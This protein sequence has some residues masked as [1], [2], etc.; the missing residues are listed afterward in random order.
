[1]LTDK[2]EEIEFTLACSE[3]RFPDRRY[4]YHPQIKFYIREQGEFSLYDQTEIVHG[5]TNP[6][7]KQKFNIPCYSG[8]V[9]NL[10]FELLD[11]QSN[12]DLKFLGQAIV[13]SEEIFH[14]ANH[15][16]VI[17]IMSLTHKVCDLVLRWRVPTQASK[18]L[19]LTVEG[20]DLKSHTSSWFSKPDIKS[21]FRIDRWMSEDD[22]LNVYESAQVDEPK[23][24]KWQPFRIRSSQISKNEMRTP[25][26]IKFLYYEND[27]EKS[28]GEAVFTLDQ[29]LNGSTLFPLLDK[30]KQ[31]RLGSLRI[32]CQVLEKMNYLTEDLSEAKLNIILGIDFSDSQKRINCSDSTHLK[33][34]DQVSSQYEAGLTNLFNLLY[35]L[36]CKQEIPV[37]GFGG[38]KTSSSPKAR[39]EEN[40][41]CFSITRNPTNYKVSS[42]T[43]VI[44]DYKKCILN[45]TLGG[46]ANFAEI[47]QKA[48]GIASF[49]QLQGDKEYTILVLLTDGIIQDLENTL[50]SIIEA[51]NI[52]LSIIMIGI[53]DGD[54]ESFENLD[55]QL[56]MYETARRDYV[57]FIAYRD[58]IEDTNQLKKK[59]MQEIPEQ[60]LEYVETEPNL[61]DETKESVKKIPAYLK[62]DLYRSGREYI[63]ARKQLDGFLRRS[64]KQ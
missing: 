40:M 58:F 57:S 12:D 22:Y 5:V 1:M 20:L 16:K 3:I 31:K 11:S 24:P 56:G 47:I 52:P 48:I 42:L 18:D 26:K 41:S 33:E 50:N 37:Y 10:K 60:I 4:R 44:D 15:T 19:L 32:K 29:I 45:N 36:N 30:T 49:N 34:D 38:L 63:K 62:E 53:G 2:V 61:I 46:H 21:F 35:D 51:A 6:I 59:L 27:L 54:F 13:N 25:I 39:K 7:F 55:S 28:L 23:N 64:L 8:V 43:E 9:L 17:E 14:S